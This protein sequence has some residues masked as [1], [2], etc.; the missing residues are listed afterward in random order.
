MSEKKNPFAGY[1]QDKVAS[2]TAVIEAH[3]LELSKNR[4][5]FKYITDLAAAVADKVGSVEG[6]PCNK[7]TLLRN[8]TYKAKLLRYMA[9]NCGAVD[10]LAKAEANAMTSE[11]E[12]GNLRRENER[13]K[14]YIRTLER[15][16]DAQGRDVKAPAL[17]AA[18][19]GQLL[20]DYALTCKALATVLTEFNEI[21]MMAEDGAILDL[22]RVKGRQVLV[23]AKTAEPFVR[24]WKVNS[25]Q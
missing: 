17:T 2:R 9:D 16:M 6:V 25:A 13:L 15:R 21:L 18:S 22:A 24:W 3:L 8:V 1:Q 20:Q 14:A 11:L 19:D 12:A 5:Q 10:S 7:A 23:D 4:T